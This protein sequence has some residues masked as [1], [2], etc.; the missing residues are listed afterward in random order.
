M[1]I[2][3]S[4]H[5]WFPHFSAMFELEDGTLIKKE[6]VPIKPVRKFLPPIFFKGKVVITTYVVKDIKESEWL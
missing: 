5:G 1:N 2:R 6:Y 3:I 4:K